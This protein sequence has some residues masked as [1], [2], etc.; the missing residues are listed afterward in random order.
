MRLKHLTNGTALLVVLGTS[1]QA[2]IFVD[3]FEA[4]SSGSYTVVD[5]ANGSSGDGSANST[6]Q[7]AFDYI[8]AGISL[9]P[10]SSSGDRSGLRFTA[11]D[12]D[13]EFDH[14]TAFHNTPVTVPEYILRVDVFM[15]VDTN[16]S[17]TTEHGHV[18]VAGSSTNFLSL[19]NP[20]VDNGHFIAFTGD[21]GS[22]SDFRHSVPGNPAVPSGDDSYLNSDNTTNAT[23]D[24]YQEIFS[25]ANGYTDFPGSPGN[26][27]ATLEI[28]VAGG[29][30]T[31]G[32]NGTPII[33]DVYSEAGGNLV[34]LG[35]GDLF[36]SVGP[37][38]VIY[39]NLS[40]TAVPEPGTAGLLGLAGLALIARRRRSC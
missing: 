14:I 16:A 5:E 13:G 39:D 20:V 15:S 21:G 2:A 4:D 31:Y 27:W 33:R 35:L 24:T 12:S 6:A 1:V 29:E 37:H 18:G 23:G 30:I 25:E 7:F 11:N 32:F 10:N 38:F 9:A 19:F 26:N 17:G 28:T 8:A 3:N 34:S 36:T 22:A 40:V